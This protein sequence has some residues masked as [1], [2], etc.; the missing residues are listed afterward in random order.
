MQ[1]FRGELPSLLSVG[2]TD[3]KIE[4]PSYIIFLNFLS[5][6]VQSKASCSSE[7]TDDAMKNSLYTFTHIMENVSVQ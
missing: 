5:Y 7:S 3:L 1:S 2:R 4:T 6:Y